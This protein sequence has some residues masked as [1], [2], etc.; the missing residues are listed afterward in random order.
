MLREVHL[1][2]VEHEY[3]NEDGSL[4]A[5]YLNRE[6]ADKA[7]DLLNK[8]VA[9]ESAYGH[10]YGHYRVQT[11]LLLDRINL[12]KAPFQAMRDYPQ[13]HPVWSLWRKVFPNDDLPT[14][15]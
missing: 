14:Q 5:A 2:L 3:T 15:P 10:F 7:C 9:T 6:V 8:L 11:V 1:V 12:Q 13:N 4:V